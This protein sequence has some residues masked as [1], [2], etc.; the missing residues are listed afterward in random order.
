MA[1][2]ESFNIDDYEPYEPGEFI[3]E[4]IAASETRAPALVPG[5]MN[6]VAIGFGLCS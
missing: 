1:Q 6:V 2:A 5:I 3:I 4:D